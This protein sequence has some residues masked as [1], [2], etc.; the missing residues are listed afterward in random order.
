M[1]NTLPRGNSTHVHALATDAGVELSIDHP[2]AFD[3]HLARIVNGDDAA[4][5]VDL[6]RDQAVDLAFKLLR[7]SGRDPLEVTAGWTLRQEATCR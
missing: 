2:D 4:G 6:S 7:A 3:R 5:L 1:T